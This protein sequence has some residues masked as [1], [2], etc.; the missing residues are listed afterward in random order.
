M[1]AEL[2]HMIR[3]LFARNVC[4]RE[5]N[6]QRGVLNAKFLGQCMRNLLQCCIAG[7]ATGSDQVCCEGIFRGAH[8]PDV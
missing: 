5:F 6:L 7:V 2:E 1:R 4:I 8:G 3:R